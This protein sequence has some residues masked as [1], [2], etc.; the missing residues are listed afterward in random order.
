[1]V[2]FEQAIMGV[3]IEVNGDWFF[4]GGSQFFL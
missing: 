4:N 1:M 3:F 2:G